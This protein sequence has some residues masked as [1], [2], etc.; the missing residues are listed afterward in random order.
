M[1]FLDF[2]IFVTGLSC[3]IWIYLLVFHHRFWL[4]NQVLKA[5]A[6]L[7]DEEWP[8]VVVI[9]PARNE[10][11][12]IEAV[13]KRH[14][15]NEYQGQLDLIVVDD[16]SSDGTGDLVRALGSN[17]AHV[18]EGKD[19]P[20]GWSGKLWAVNNGLVAAKEIAPKASYVLLSDA[21]IEHAPGTLSKLVSKAVQEEQAMVSIMA[22]L[23]ARGFW[24]GLLMPAF[25]FF[26]QKLYPFP[27]INHPASKIGGAAG[28]CMLI[29]RKALDEIGGVETI[30]GD[31]IDD[32][33]LGKALKDPNGAKRSTWLGF[34]DGVV[35]LRDNRELHTIWKMVARTAFTQLRFSSLLLLGSVIG[36]A[37]TYLVAPM[38]FLTLSLHGS[39]LASTLGALAYVGMTLAYTPT[40]RRYKKSPLW[41]LI[42]PLSAIV[43]MMMTISSALNHWRGRGGAWKGRTY[44]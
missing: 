6:P 13:A 39:I 19:L 25:I 23:D 3:A 38:V 32:C 40:L 36:M 31:L 17:R 9:I 33:A 37:L 35:S 29:E 24:G 22:M 12:T 10:A 1:T 2:I 34:D 42:L 21:D 26:F 5:S 16:Q 43:Y 41:A 8:D 15:E 14:L 20:D 11:E 7:R 28:G 44:S 4:S 18:I 30:K 27:A